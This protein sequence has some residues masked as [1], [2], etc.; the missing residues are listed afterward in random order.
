ME[1][2]YAGLSCN[3]PKCECHACTQ[4][5]YRMS[6]DNY[7]AS[8]TGVYFFTSD[9]KADTSDTKADGPKA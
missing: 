4:A 9:T 2:Q 5:R 1:H 8:N 3:P 6:E 7:D